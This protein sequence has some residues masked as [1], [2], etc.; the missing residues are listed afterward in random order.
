MLFS[1]LLSVAS[2]ASDTEKACAA[3]VECLLTKLSWCHCFHA[4][5]L[6]SSICINSLS[7]S[8]SEASLSRECQSQSS[9]IR[10]LTFIV[11]RCSSLKLF[12]KAMM[13]R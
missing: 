6:N 7:L 12:T 9:S 3:L 4:R 10:P 8:Q 1:L 2:M 5:L 11:M 13:N